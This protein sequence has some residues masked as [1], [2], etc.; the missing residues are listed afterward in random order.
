[1]KADGTPYL[2]F[3]PYG[4]AWRKKL[5]DYHAKAYPNAKYFENFLKQQPIAIPSLESMG[6]EQLRFHCHRLT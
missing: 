4:K 3:S 1:M 6:L 5:T 2:V